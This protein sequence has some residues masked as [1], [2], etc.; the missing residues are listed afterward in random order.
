M[1]D[2]EVTNHASGGY[3][4]LEERVEQVIEEQGYTIDDISG[5]QVV[6]SLIVDK[7]LERS[8][9]KERRMAR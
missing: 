6:K 4:E 8:A 2:I 3:N 7:I 5:D 9:L 1:D